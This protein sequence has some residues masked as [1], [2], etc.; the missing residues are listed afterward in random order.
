MSA[1]S[2][3]AR[4][5]NAAEPLDAV[6]ARVAARACD[7]I[8]FEYCAVMLADADGERLRVEGWRG[9]SPHYLSLLAGGGSLLVHPSGPPLDTPAARAFREGR[10]VAVPDA[11]VATDYGRL[12]GLA[13]AQGYRALVAVPLPV[14]ETDGGAA[15]PAGV[16]VGYS[17]AARDFAPS[18]IE[19]VELLAG[20]A[21][22]ALET[23]RLRAAQQE[24]I[25][26]LSRANDE[27]RRGR[28][29]L[30]WAEQRHRELMQ[31]VL[32]EVG[33]AGLVAALA[34]T[35]DASV[36]VE[37]ADGGLLASAP[38]EG[39]RP[40]PDTAARRRAPAREALED[41]ARRYEVVR[42]PVVAP[43][44]PVLRGAPG[45]E[46][47]ETAWVVPVVLGQ[48]LVGR[49]WVTAPSAV[50]APVQLRVI[51]RFALVVALELLKARHLVAVEGRLSGDLVTD[52]LRPDGPLHPQSLLDRA[53]ALGHD[54]G[55]PQTVAVLA[56]DGDLP[57]GVRV[58][59]LVRAAAW[60][61]AVPL[62]G[63]HEDGHVLL[64]PAD[65][66]PGDV[67]RRVHAQLA[68]LAGPGCPVTL[69]AGPT[70]HTPEEYAPAYRVARGAARLRRAT[71][72]GGFVDVGQL[73]LSALLLET[74]APDALRRFA[75]SVLHPLVLHDERRGGD[76]VPTLRVWLWTGCSTT[77]T[78]AELVIHPNTVG[79][80]LNRIEQLTGRSLRGIDT[81]LEL[82]LALTVR[83]II[84]LDET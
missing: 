56:V 78:A 22:L 43:N 36:T 18:E 81:R 58:P 25:G 7:L 8:G 30:E 16:L 39:Y 63:A 42:I 51:E 14:S 68:Q 31:L 12:P 40:P 37:D 48:E 20:Q 9:L 32:D 2:E 38:E 17:V 13:S 50:P 49:L 27:L 6:L 10:T 11:R 52:L 35:L 5:V 61:D 84:R 19:L 28:A 70:A 44:G 34:R 83:D 46:R 1:V 80:R 4:A 57:G 47:R 15:A 75:H 79:Y 60:P 69:V 26:E 59:E 54:L 77:A 72:P 71:R 45:H 33:L 29:V 67:L 64:V 53:A 41:M 73:G 62:V 55:V 65:V 66:E 82:Q 74:G 23:A 21:A 3:I 24:V 76:L